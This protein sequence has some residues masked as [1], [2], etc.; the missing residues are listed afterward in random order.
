MS[1][2]NKLPTLV[3]VYLEYYCNIFENGEVF[4]YEIYKEED[5]VDWGH[6]LSMYEYSPGDLVD[7]LIGKMNDLHAIK[8]E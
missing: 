3:F 5:V 7:L 4:S 1:N 2:E 8:Y 6:S